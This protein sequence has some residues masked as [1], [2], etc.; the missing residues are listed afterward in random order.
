MLGDRVLNAWVGTAEG[1]II[2]FPTYSYTDNVGGGNPNVWKNI[3]HND[4]HL[5]W[6]FIYFGYDWNKKT[7]RAFIKFHDSE[8]EQ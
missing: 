8:A 7:A 3:K 2:H 5:K 6:H 4:K 1:G